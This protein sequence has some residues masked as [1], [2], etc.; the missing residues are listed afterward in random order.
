MKVAEE[1]TSNGQ[2]FETDPDQVLLLLRERKC[3][4]LQVSVAAQ[5]SPQYEWKM[6]KEIFREMGDRGAVEGKRE[7]ERGER[8][9]KR[10]KKQK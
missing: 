1:L 10:E 9:E 5:S 7:R 4:C 6:A 8:G 2:A 3:M